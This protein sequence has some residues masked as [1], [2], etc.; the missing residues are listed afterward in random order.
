MAQ[1]TTTLIQELRAKTNAGMMDCKKALTEA[2]GDIETAVGI[3]RKKGIAKAAKRSDR[4]ANEGVIKI[5]TSGNKAYMVELDSETDFVSANEKFTGLAD[6]I[7]DQLIASDTTDFEKFCKL[8][9]ASGKS[10][11]DSVDELSGTLGEKIDLKRTAVINGSPDDALGSYIHMNNKIGVILVLENAKGL[12]NFAKDVCMHIAAT[13]PQYISDKDIPEA[14]LKKEKEILKDQVLS[15]G[16]P[17]NIADKIVE[18]KIRKYYEDNC[19]L[20]QSFVKN[21]E[22]T[23]KGLIAKTSKDSGKDISIKEFVRFAIGS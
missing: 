5:R 1:I 22:L 14:E 15:Q 23:I 21:P 9:L 8:N 11:Q 18:G 16:K 6:S 3:L 13:N 7:L 20:Y 2:D 10:V 4:E 19:L 12:N 17:E